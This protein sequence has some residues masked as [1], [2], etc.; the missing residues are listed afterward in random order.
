MY[1]LLSDAPRAED[2]LG[3][4]PMAD[5]LTVVIR[6]TAP[7]FTIGVFGE[8]GSGKTTLMTLVRQRLDERDNVKTVWFN[9]WKYDG[10]EVIWNALIQSIFYAMREDPAFRDDSAFLE[11]IKSAAI[12]LAGFAARKWAGALTG[13]LLDTKEMDKALGALKPL[14]ATDPEFGFIN[15]F[16]VTFADLVRDYVG[17]DGRLVIF[18]DDLDRCLPENAVSVLEAI[19]LHL[20]NAQVTF[21]IGVEPEVIRE[22]IRHRY[23]N[24]EVL[25]EKEYLEKIIQLPFVM[26]GLDHSA[27]MELIHPYAKTDS[28][29]YDD[30]VI[31]LLL[32][33]TQA[34]PRRIKR[35]INSFYVLAEMRRAAGAPLNDQAD[36]QR[37]ALTL[38]TQTHFRTVYEFLVEE[39]DIVQRFNHLMR[40]SASEREAEVARS[41]A[42]TAIFED[43]AAR[44][45]LDLVRDADCSGEKMR[46]WVLLTRGGEPSAS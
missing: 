1:E 14:V 18:V 25:A 20:D 16:E 45:F 36:V 2:R 32:D 11:R 26:R 31:A 34:N 46:E 9:A 35:F 27:A 19:K 8:W 10:K 21:V 28:Y 24:N 15:A 17:E 23:R 30:V 3:F 40:K 38:L 44:R 42:L 37:L 13:G 22:G 6:R 7:P 43:A 5:I 4:A 12:G 29:A 33:A 41:P 39:P